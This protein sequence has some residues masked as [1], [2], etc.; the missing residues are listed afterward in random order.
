[1]AVI[2][3]RSEQSFEDSVGPSGDSGI[4]VK[5]LL[6]T[7]CTTRAFMPL[8]GCTEEI[9]KKNSEKPEL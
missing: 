9:D 6:H 7:G 8:T 3:N 4:P 5:Q 1:M 2:W